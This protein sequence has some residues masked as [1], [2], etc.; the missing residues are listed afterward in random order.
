MSRRLRRKLLLQTNGKSGSGADAQVRI[1]NISA[2]GLLL[3]CDVPL[4]PGEA[5]EV[6]LPQA[7]RTLATIAWVSEN[8]HGCAFDNPISEAA[9]S[10]ARLQGTEPGRMK[11]P[12][13]AEAG[14]ETLGAILQRARTAA[15]LSLAE[16]GARLGVSKPTVWAWEHDRARPLE[17]RLDEIAEAL[18]LEPGLLR[19][20]HETPAQ[21]ALVNRAREE[22]ARAY[23]TTPERVLIMVSL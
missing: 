8:F 13:D 23:G 10:A 2:N 19:Q 18:G 9:I 12:E 11:L 3:E 21:R 20:G 5:I 14:E 17:E 4:E 15:G 16:V 7:G 22:I 1:H 6:D